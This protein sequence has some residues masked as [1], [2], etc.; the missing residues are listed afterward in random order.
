MRRQLNAVG[1]ARSQKISLLNDGA[2][3]TKLSNDVSVPFL[4]LSSSEVLL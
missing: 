4:R 3:A 1:F 2:S